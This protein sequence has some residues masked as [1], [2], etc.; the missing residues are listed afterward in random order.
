MATSPV[1]VTPVLSFEA[2]EGRILEAT[3]KQPL[4]LT[5]EESGCLDELENLVASY[6]PGYFDVVHLTGHADIANGVPLFITESETGD[7][8]DSTPQ[9]I[10]KALQFRFPSLLF[11]SGCRTGQSGAR[12]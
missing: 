6:D 5:V 1:G 9:D 3:K 11:L 4:T 10:A 7:R 8:L 12:G 2:E